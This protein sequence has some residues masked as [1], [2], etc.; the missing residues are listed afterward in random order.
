MA[1]TVVSP[2]SIAEPVGAPSTSDLLGMITPEMM[3]G[4]STIEEP[5]KEGVEPETPVDDG[6]IETP[7]VT[8]PEVDAEPGPEPEP[9]APKEP[10]PPKEEDIPEGVVKGKNR[11]G[12]E[13]YFATPERWEKIYGAYKATQEVSNLLGEPLTAAAVKGKIEAADSWDYLIGDLASGDK[14]AQGNTVDYLMQRMSQAHK[15]GET[16]VDP[17]VSFVDTLYSKLATAG[18]NSP[19]YRTMRLRNTQDLVGE[20]FE[21]AAAAKDDSLA[22]GIQHVVRHLAGIGPTET[23]P[24]IVK[25][26]AERMGLPFRLL[27]ELPTLARGNTPEAQLRAEIVSLRNQ[28]NGKGSAPAAVET[29]SQWDGA[30]RQSVDK[31]VLD[32]VILP[33][34]TAQKAAWSKLPDGDKQFE[35]RI[36]KPLQDELKG[37]LDK[38]TNYQNRLTSLKDQAKRAASVDVRK[39]IAQD[40]ATLTSNRAKLS[41]EDLKVPHVKFAAELVKQQS[42]STHQRRSGAQQRTVPR[43]ASAPVNRGLVPAA[44]VVYPN[45]MFDPATAMADA[46]A[47]LARLTR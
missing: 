8:E 9:E 33:A 45:G 15:N 12:E 13:G 37:V 22:A 7:E 11:K 41:I 42:D 10:E 43:G 18:T 40:I 34:L 23:N 35:L 5:P 25:A 26:A 2:A 4:A 16:A 14:T 29:Y 38:D 6:E 28:I 21:A 36:L 30:T 19:A 39:R 31:T 20:L 44:D 24:A 17:S 32:S 46:Q 3:A 1:T 27:D 47:R